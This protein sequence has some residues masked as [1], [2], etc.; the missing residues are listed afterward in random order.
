MNADWVPVPEAIRRVVAAVGPLGDEEV[1]LLAT[2]GRVLAED[3]VSPIDLPL[4]T[5]SAMDGFAVCWDD[6]RGASDTSP[7]VLP[8]TEDVPAGSFPSHPL[9]ARTAIRVM[10]GAPV[11]EGAD[12]VIRVEH[13]D[14]G[15]GIGSADALVTI[16]SDQDGGRNLR[17]Q[18]EEIRRG[19]IALRS[20]T[21]LDPGAIGVC[22]SM[23]RRRVRVVRSPVVA[24]LTSGDEL[25]EVEG[26]EEVLAGR[27]IVSSNSYSLRALLEEIGCRVVDLGIAADS[28]E[29]LRDALRGAAGCDAVVTSAGISVGE[30]DY[31]RQ[32]L[33]ELDTEVLL[34]RVKM[35]PGSP[36]AFGSIGALGGIPWF[37]LPGNPV[38]SMVTFE[39]FARPALLR[40]SGRRE[41]FRR[42]VAARF[43]GIYDMP[44]GLTNLARVTLDAGESGLLVARLTGPQ[45][46]GILRSVAAADGL[47]VIREDRGG[48]RTGDELPVIPFASYLLSAEPPI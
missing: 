27:K 46:S 37:G 7:V 6:V 23:G 11:P 24:L 42:T 48:A 10:T 9:A 16:H 18:G 12:T 40:M 15:R 19:Q 13:T 26:Y 33:R 5:N 44:P 14:G 30:H 4:W 1:E 38:S 17:R 41:V 8:V 2:R 36:F 21:I 32:V 20:G 39:L 22:A 47:M 35:R 28:P 29:S 43:E 3:L 34:W 31:V 45:G 25:V